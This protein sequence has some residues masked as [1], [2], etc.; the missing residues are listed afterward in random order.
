MFGR[1]KKVCSGEIKKYVSEKFRRIIWSRYNVRKKSYNIKEFNPTENHVEKAYI[2]V[3]IKWRA[4]MLIT[5][6][7]IGSHQL[8]C[9]TG[10]WWVPKEEWENRACIFCDRGAVE[11][12]HHFVMECSTYNDIR[13]GYIEILEK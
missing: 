1:N 2:G 9:E 13:S 11:M 3:D 10:G 5:Q 12:E 8:R 6:L 7:R 4:K